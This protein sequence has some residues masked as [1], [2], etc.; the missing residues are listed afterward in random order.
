MAAPQRWTEEDDLTLRLVLEEADGKAS[1]GQVTKRAFPDGKHT[2]KDCQD[3]RSSSRSVLC[4]IR[5]GQRDSLW[6]WPSICTAR[7][8]RDAMW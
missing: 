5:A 6:S 3:V 1:W 7:Q 8:S 4:W 2:K